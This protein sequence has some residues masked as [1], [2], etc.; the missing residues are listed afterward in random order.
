MIGLVSTMQAVVTN[1]ASMVALRFL[2]GAVEAMY[3]GAPYFLSFFYPR[4]KVGIRQGI[5]LSGSALAN[6]YGGSLGYAIGNIKGSI[7]PWRYL[8]IIEGIPSC[9]AAGLAWWLIPDNIMAAKF[10]ND[11][12]KVVAVHF[13][14]KGLY[15]DVDAPTGVHWKQYFLAFVDYRSEYIRS[16]PI[17]SCG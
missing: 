15:M 2:L 16:F 11:R 9:L 14:Q 10:L 3:A 4:H 13:M 12:E 1:Y 17:L 6:A 5:F 8:F 7:A